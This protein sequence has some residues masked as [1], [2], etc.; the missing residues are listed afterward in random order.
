MKRFAILVATAALFATPALA[1][2]AIG[3]FQVGNL[4]SHSVMQG[5]S[6]AS[7]GSINGS[8]I[9][10]A[11][12]SFNSVVTGSNGVTTGLAQMTPGGVVTA[13][14]LNTTTF[15]TTV[16]LGGALGLSGNLTQMGGQSQ[17]LG[18]SEAL[19]NVTAGIGGLHV[20]F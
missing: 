14:T 17:A 1:F 2:D 9:L 12:G 16:N 4:Q 18:G 3:G 6:E 8:A 15:G 13:S 7:I 5:G 19:G 11:N 20:G 10:G